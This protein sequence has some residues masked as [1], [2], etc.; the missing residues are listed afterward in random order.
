MIR[1][2]EYTDFEA[3]KH[4]RVTG[5]YYLGPKD[6]F[7]KL[8]FWYCCPSGS[9]NIQS[10][11]VGDSFKPVLSGIATWKLTGQPGSPTLHPSVN[12]V[13]V[14]HGWLRGGYWESC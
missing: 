9:G 14:W 12:H 7:Q 2:I 13:G 8:D 1:A 3:F 10:I 4:D 11:V 6:D 5:S